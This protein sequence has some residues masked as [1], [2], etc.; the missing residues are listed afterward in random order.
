MAIDAIEAE[1]RSTSTA[2]G[3]RFNSDN[4]PRNGRQL[5]CYR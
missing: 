2:R 3:S 1:S 4:R 5:V